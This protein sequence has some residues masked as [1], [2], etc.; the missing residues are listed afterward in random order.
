[1][2]E[3]T[4]DQSYCEVSEHQA[5]SGYT[6]GGFGTETCFCICHTEGMFR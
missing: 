5:C 3:P 1:M 4:K 6:E 2:N